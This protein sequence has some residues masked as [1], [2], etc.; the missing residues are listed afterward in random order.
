MAT[1]REVAELAAVF[2]ATASRVLNGSAHPVS[3]DV[4]ASVRT[5]TQTLVYTPNAATQ[6]LKQQHSKI[7]GVIASDI[8]DPYL[9]NS[10]AA[11]RSKPPSPATSRF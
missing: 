7:I 4:T 2:V 6:A 11:S 3:S 1:L 8:L 10:R 9:P 5:A